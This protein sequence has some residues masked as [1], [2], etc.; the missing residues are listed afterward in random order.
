[1]SDT[2]REF[3]LYLIPPGNIEGIVIFFANIITVVI[4]IEVL[5]ML[6][7][8]F[9]NRHLSSKTEPFSATDRIGKKILLLGD[10]TA[11]GTGAD[12]PE[13]TIAGKLAHDFPSTQI[14]NYGKNG[15]R[16][17]DL[18][19]QLKEVQEQ[20]FDM[21]LICTGGNDIWNFSN[22]KKLEKNLG[23]A[24]DEAKEISDHRV[25]F[26]LY[27]NIGSAPIF[28]GIIRTIL[29][30]R[31]ERVHRK[32]REITREKQV[33]CVELF[34]NKKDNPFLEKPGVLFAS[35]GIHPSSEGYKIWYNRMWR[36]M[37]EEGFLFKEQYTSQ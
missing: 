6:I 14:I 3:I 20:K 1:M 21:V 31:G 22:L 13:D 11:V 35:D 4:V 9:K 29:E 27:N 30:P 8:L 7:I 16:V 23:M 33:P 24:L 10:S 37:V 28:P 12:K 19:H 36:T 25:I 2:I 34:A 15:T 17:V 5:R 18:L 32:F 26:L